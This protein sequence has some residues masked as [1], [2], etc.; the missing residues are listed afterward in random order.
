MLHILQ[1]KAQI[2]ESRKTLQ[3][4]SWSTIG[5]LVDRAKRRFKL[6][7]GLAVGD[8]VKSW[9]VLR[10]LEFINEHLSKQDTIVDFGAYC[11]EVPVALNKIGF[12]SVY[13]VDLNP[14]IQLMPH[15]EEINYVVSDF[16][17]SPLP[18]QSARAITAISVIEHGYQADRLFGEVSRLL[19]DEGYF[20]A[21][22][23]YCPE[24]I[25][26]GDTKFFGMDWRI[27]SKDELAKMID[28]ASSFHLYPVGEMNYATS[29]NPIRC[30]GFQYT[31]GWIVFQKRIAC[32]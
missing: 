9:D 19:G 8:M 2:Y 10:S 25:D 11:S 24:K 30:A 28:V 15:A 22:F 17:Q 21:S 32:A 23:D 3:L 20:I 12:K 13:G 27:F 1:T 4:K 16:L 29:S 26:V 14:D 5:G 31:F 6:G 18:D 7:T